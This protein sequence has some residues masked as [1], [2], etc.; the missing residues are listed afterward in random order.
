MVGLGYPYAV[1][2]AVIHGAYNGLMVLL[3][4]SQFRF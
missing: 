1:A 4:M 3:S 2:A